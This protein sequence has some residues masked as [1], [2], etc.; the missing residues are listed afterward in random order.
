VNPIVV[1]NGRKRIVSAGAAIR[2]CVMECPLRGSL[3]C[4]LT[5]EMRIKFHLP[6]HGRFPNTESFKLKACGLKANVKLRLW[7]ARSK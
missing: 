5:C 2:F 3:G 6:P 4:A 7:E 1:R